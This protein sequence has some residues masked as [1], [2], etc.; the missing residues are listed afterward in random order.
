MYSDGNHIFGLA[1]L[2]GT[3]DAKNEDL[4]T[5]NFTGSHKWELVHDGHVMMIVEYTNP[6]LPSLKIN[7]EIFDDLL[8]RT[9]LEISERDLKKLWS[10]VNIAT[11]QKHGTLLIISNESEQESKRLEYQSI[12]IEPV[13]LGDD[14][15][16]TVTSIDG[17]ILLDSSGIC[18]SIGVILDGIATDKGTS[19]RGARFNSAVRYVENKKKKCVA[20]IISEDGMVDLYPQLL[21]RIKKSEIIEHLEKLRNEVGLAK[22]NYDKYRPLMNWLW[23]HEFYL[24]QEQCSEIN[25]LKKIFDSKLEMELSAIY[26]MY[27]DLAPNSEMDDSYFMEDI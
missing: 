13:S 15:I 26:I 7:K 12:K 16:K 6:G 22:V 24:T 18:H 11:E 3:Y 1:R 20:V 27:P 8:K 17:A 5:I 2:K 23:E 19:A 9:F 10:I 25:N 4:V 21:P 14:L